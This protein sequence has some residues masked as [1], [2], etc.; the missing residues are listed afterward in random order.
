MFITLPNKGYK[1]S[2]ITLAAILGSMKKD[3]M[4]KVSPMQIYSRIDIFLIPLL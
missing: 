2:D 4:L 1:S 3:N